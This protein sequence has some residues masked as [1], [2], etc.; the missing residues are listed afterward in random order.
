MQA[1]MIGL[2]RMGGNMTRRLLRE[3]HQ[4]IAYDLQPEAVTALAREGALPAHSLAELVDRLTPPR[5]CWL[6]LPAARVDAQIEQLAP[7][8]APGDTL[9]DGGNSTTG[10][11]CAAPPACS[12]PAS[13]MSTSASAAA[14][15]DSNAATAR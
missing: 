13:A 9:V 3:G 4:V 11:T 8:L 5:V 12:K 15:G 6:M 7:L 10:T 1:G 14:S 2:G